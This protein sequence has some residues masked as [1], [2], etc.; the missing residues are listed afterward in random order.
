M[1]VL[2]NAGRYLLDVLLDS[3]FFLVSIMDA[4]S[5]WLSA[6]PVRSLDYWL[7]FLWWTEGQ[8]TSTLQPLSSRSQSWTFPAWNIPF[9]YITSVCRPLPSSC[10]SVCSPQF[11]NSV[12]W[13]A[14][15]PLFPFLLF[16]SPLILV[17]SY[18]HSFELPCR[19]AGWVYCTDLFNH[20]LITNAVMR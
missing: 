11:F 19:Q 4:L 17:P 14:S 3:L 9:D 2:P 10:S 15:L 20:S 16:G 5:F 13:S 18:R 7:F 12:R 6:P 1:R 8:R